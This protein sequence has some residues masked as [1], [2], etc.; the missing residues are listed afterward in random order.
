MQRPDQADPEVPAHQLAEVLQRAIN[1]DRSATAPLSVTAGE[2]VDIAT[3]LGVASDAVAK[4]LAEWRLDGVDGA[5]TESLGWGSRLAATL[6]GPDR[7][8]VVRTC[9]VPSRQAVDAVAKNLARQ[10]LLQIV[11]R[12]GDR[13]VARRRSDPVAAAGRVMRAMN[14][15]APLNKVSEVR[16]AVGQLPDA[17]AA[18]CLRADVRDGRSGAIAAGCSIGTLC[19][20][21][22]VFLALASSPW[23][24]LA[25]PSVVASG[26]FAARW[27]HRGLLRRVRNS[28]EDLAESA[29]RGQAPAS[30]FEHLGRVVGRR[31][32]R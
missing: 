19:A 17:A 12:D 26:L 32:N 30:V 5:N 15:R 3:E 2:L 22:V 11:S 16:A 25:V 4:A 9:R 7:V 6:V 21:V 27:A 18:L 14:G 28:L 23:W 31:Q 29:A 8:T 10:H 1:L 24:V 13:L 20:G